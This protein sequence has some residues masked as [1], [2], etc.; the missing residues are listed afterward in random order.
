V[1]RSQ[2]ACPFQIILNFMLLLKLSTALWCWEIGMGSI[3]NGTVL[4][5]PKYLLNQFF[6][7]SCMVK[8]QSYSHILT[9]EYLGKHTYSVNNLYGGSFHVK[10]PLSYQ[11]FTHYVKFGK[12]LPTLLWHNHCL[13]ILHLQPAVHQYQ[14]WPTLFHSAYILKTTILASPISAETLM[15]DP[16]ATTHVWQNPFG[17]GFIERVND[18]KACQTHYIICMFKRI[19]SPCTFWTKYLPYA[20][21][22]VVVDSLDHQCNFHYW[23]QSKKKLKPIVAHRVKEVLAICLIILEIPSNSL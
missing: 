22:P 20:P 10:P 5:I 14:Q 11:K 2:L 15:L 13:F 23:L 17:L 8:I 12:Y 19:Q 7:K 1:I 18:F 9:E 4:R 21:G 3:T 16:R 6:L